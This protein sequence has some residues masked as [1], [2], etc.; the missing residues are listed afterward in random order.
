[1]YILIEVEDN[2]QE[3]LK[4]LSRR[5]N[6]SIV[7]DNLNDIITSWKTA[8]YEDFVNTNN[9]HPLKNE[10]IDKINLY[11][12]FLS[13]KNK[14]R[15]SPLELEKIAHISNLEVIELP[16]YSLSDKVETLKYMKKNLEPYE[17]LVIPTSEE[18]INAVFA[19]LDFFL[20]PRELKAFILRYV[21]MEKG[22]KISQSMGCSSARVYQI[23][24][25]ARVKMLHKKYAN[26][27]K[28][29]SESCSKEKEK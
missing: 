18:S 9:R 24:R 5:K 8:L 3:I 28:E 14:K 16:R 6:K 23:L 20:L 27:V 4:L 11:S 1:M 22:E 7:V 13:I 10:V 26:S 19:R 17:N 21:K 25:D 15:H 2:E 29:K 12:W